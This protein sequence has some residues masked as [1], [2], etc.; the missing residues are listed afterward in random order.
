[1]SFFKSIAPFVGDILDAALGALKS[2]R[3]WFVEV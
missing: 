1:M 3:M 2:E